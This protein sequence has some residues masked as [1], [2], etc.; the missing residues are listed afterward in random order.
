MPRKIKLVFHSS[1]N[2]RL[3][4]IVSPLKEY[5]LAFAVNQEL[6]FD[7]ERCDDLAYAYS[8][9]IMGTYAWY[10]FKDL[11]TNTVFYLIGNR[12]P[13]GNL[14]PSVKSADFFILIKNIHDTDEIKAY[15]NKL[16]SIPNIITALEVNPETV[17]D[18][19][20][21]LDINELHEMEQLNRC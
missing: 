8:G 13:G 1:D 7:F 14:I 16:K 9:D 21:L 6:E 11:N 19:E 5:R 2:Y 15:I 17:K 20:M 4:A 12:H 18:L 10:H 3:I